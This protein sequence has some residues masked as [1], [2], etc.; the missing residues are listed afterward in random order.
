M[1][2]RVS[3]CWERLRVRGGGGANG[4]ETGVVLEDEKVVAFG[5]HGYL[6]AGIGLWREGAVYDSALEGDLAE[7]GLEVRDVDLFVHALGVPDLSFGLKAGTSIGGSEAIGGL[8]EHATAG[9]GV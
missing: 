7:T 9:D 3:W 4:D 8:L 1:G 2:G 6:G 5:E